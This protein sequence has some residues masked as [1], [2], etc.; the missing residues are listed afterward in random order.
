M[1]TPEEKRA[2]DLKALAS[3]ALDA[4]GVSGDDEVWTGP[5][6]E[7]YIVE[8]AIAQACLEIEAVEFTLEKHQDHADPELSQLV[9]VVQGI[10]RR[11]ELVGQCTETLAELMSTTTETAANG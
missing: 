11:L 1:M 7:S 9:Y 8:H 3:R 2:I 4:L 5:G 6:V 10:R